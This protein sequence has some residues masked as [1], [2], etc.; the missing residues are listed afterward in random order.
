MPTPADLR[1]REL[2]DKWLASLEL[3]AK[4]SA[5]DDASYSKIQSWPEHRRP[6]RWIIDLAIHNTLAL[7]G[8]FFCRE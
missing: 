2:L 7:Q 6:S 3:H 5:L 4:Y 1:L 8:L